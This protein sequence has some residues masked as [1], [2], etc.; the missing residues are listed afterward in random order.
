MEQS[1]RRY[2]ADIVIVGGGPAGSSLAVRTAAAGHSTV[3]IERARFPRHKLCGEFIS[4]ECLDHFRKLEVLDEM[5]EA[6]GER[7]LET[8]FFDAKGRHFS[9]PSS[10]LGGGLHALSLSR[11]TMDRILLD[12]AREAG[13][14]VIE[15][16]RATGL[17]VEEGRIAAVAAVDEKGS[18]ST[19]EGRI[20]VDATGRKRSLMRL[21]EKTVGNG[22]WK[23]SARPAAVAFK[24]HFSGS[25]LPPNVCEI[26][27]FPGGYG[28]LTTV[29]NG[30]ANLCFMV[31]PR[32]AKALG[33]QPEKLV[34]SLLI[35]NAR[36]AQTLGAARPV[37]E[38]HAVSIESFGQA[39]APPLENLFAIGD[40][41]A[42]IDPFT[43][44]GMLMAL[45]SSAL[46]ASAITVSDGVTGAIRANYNRQ[47]QRDFS[48]RL[49]V[50]SF[51]RRAA[52]FRHF[53]TAAVALLRSSRQARFLLAA[54]TRGGR[55]PARTL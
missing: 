25:G 22:I 12:R 27:A 40:S 4:P 34:T 43:G 46:L 31:D 49:R 36:L 29:E 51:L 52:S 28:G 39:P 42:F 13:V 35:R 48:R 18:R 6:G 9:V 41:A 47:Y 50:C 55:S 45:E 19:V 17:T 10:V 3:L 53:P 30:R 16:E 2:K 15:G 20:F 21:A 1:A 32:A 11:S 44:S 7:I 38:W 54:S 23:A 33:P 37:M 5:L 8:R 14:R 24:N 26:Y